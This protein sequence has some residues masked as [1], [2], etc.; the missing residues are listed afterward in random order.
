MDAS[1]AAAP[2]KKLRP[3][4]PKA[5]RGPRV[6]E[7]GLWPSGKEGDGGYSPS[8][9]P[10]VLA[11]VLIRALLP[12]AAPAS[13]FVVDPSVF[14]I[15]KSYRVQDDGRNLHVQDEDNEIMQFAIQQSLMESGHNQVS[16]GPCPPQGQEWPP[17]LPFGLAIGPRRPRWAL[18]SK[19]RAQAPSG[20]IL[21]CSEG[22]PRRSG[23]AQGSKL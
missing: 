22:D 16:L 11:A 10:D 4:A 9:F 23:S 12:P 15:P 20:V 8:G 14:E 5:P 17:R 3:R 7:S 13:P 19:Q 2:W 6:R 18:H 21:G 1:T